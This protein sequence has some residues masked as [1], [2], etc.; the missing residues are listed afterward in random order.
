MEQVTVVAIANMIQAIAEAVT[1]LSRGQTD[2]QKQKMWDWYVT[3]VERWRA[4]F[5]LD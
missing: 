1:E 4:L 2:A 3:D 5:K